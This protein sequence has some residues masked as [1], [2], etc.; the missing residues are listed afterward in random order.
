MLDKS[1]RQD[2]MDA[3]VLNEYGC[4]GAKLL[5]GSQ[6]VRSCVYINERLDTHATRADKTAADLYALLDHL[7]LEVEEV[8]AHRRIKRA[9]CSEDVDHE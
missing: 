7:G 8:E 9:A 5:K 4:G 6:A 2:L 3:G 1:L